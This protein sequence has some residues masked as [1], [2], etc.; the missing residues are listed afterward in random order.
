MGVSFDERERTAVARP[1]LR[2]LEYL[3][4]NVT[5]ETSEEVAAL[6]SLLCR[7]SIFRESRTEIF[8]QQNRMLHHISWQHPLIDLRENFIIANIYFIF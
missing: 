4:I 6:L 8:L 1:S 3:G 5:W 7:D 2:R